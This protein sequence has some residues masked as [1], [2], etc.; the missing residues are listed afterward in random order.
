[1]PTAPILVVDGGGVDLQNVVA[2][3]AGDMHTCALIGD[4]SL[5]CWGDNT[6]GQLGDGSGPTSGYVV[7]SAG[8]S[9][10]QV[11]SNPMPPGVTFTGISAKFN[12]T[13]A[14]T[15]AGTVYCWGSDSN[16]QL[17]SG[18]NWVG[19][20]LPPQKVVAVGGAING[21]L[22]T[23]TG[24]APLL[25]GP[26]SGTVAA[27]AGGSFT[28]MASGSPA[29]MLALTALSGT[30]PVG[31]TYANGLLSV[32][33]T[34]P[35]GVYPLVLTASNGV[36][37]NAVLNFTLT[38]GQAPVFT[39]ASTVTFTA[40][41]AS[42]F[43]VTATGT[44]A[45][46]F[47]ETGALPAGV[48]LSAN[49]TLSG[50]PAGGGTY[51]ITI[52]ASNGVGP[53]A[54]QTFTLVVN[55]N[56]VGIFSVFPAALDFGPTPVGASGTQVVTV[57]NIGSASAPPPVVLLQGNNRHF[58]G[59]VANATTCN[60][61]LLPGASCMVGVFFSPTSPLS[62]AAVATL[63]IG[64]TATVSL[65]GTV[66]YLAASLTPS[67]FAFPSTPRGL[68]SATETFTYTNTGNLPI[69]GILVSFSGPNFV[70][71]LSGCAGTL[72]PGAACPI[73]VTFAPTT[74]LGTKSVT[75]RVSAIKTPPVSASITGTAL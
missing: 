56:N 15:S 51:P 44:P 30:V 54:T 23:V 50:T 14:L 35:I 3:T 37:P 28:L 49:G 8:G 64:T 29:P 32:A 55:A 36:L 7:A 11:V 27:G 70:A 12:D 58:F 18:P 25:V 47:S 5:R 68:T 2:I 6:Y 53:A 63:S 52:T 31:V 45:P 21:F 74:T 42:T 59:L 65:T 69:S 72:A 75:M 40:G 46:T 33:A 26:S 22:T 48:T 73:V 61:V 17:A 4:G 19:A 1:M 66:G 57:T 9:V 67:I 71:D 13:C 41:T 39:S 10:P 38:V 24:T 20:T 43:A 16:A 62:V 60:T 34:T